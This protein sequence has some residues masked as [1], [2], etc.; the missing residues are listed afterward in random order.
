MN[1]MMINSIAN[2]IMRSI[3]TDRSTLCALLNDCDIS[4]AMLIE[5]LLDELHDRDMTDFITDA[6]ILDDAQMMNF[7]DDSRNH[8]VLFDALLQIIINLDD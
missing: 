4:I 1:E 5:T 2:R 3:A 8:R 7:N 6:S